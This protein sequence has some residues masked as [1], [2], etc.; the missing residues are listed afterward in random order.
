MQSK[1][2]AVARWAPAHFLGSSLVRGQSTE[3]RLDPIDRAVDET[4]VSRRADL[5]T[6]G[7][8]TAPQDA[9]ECH[10]LPVPGPREYGR[11]AIP[12]VNSGVHYI[13]AVQYTVVAFYVESYA[14]AWMYPYVHPVV[15][16]ILFSSIPATFS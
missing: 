3:I 13:L 7:D 5:R 6:I 14:C 15:R 8:E 11:A 16:P 2:V 10:V 9:V 4:L 1:A 12:A